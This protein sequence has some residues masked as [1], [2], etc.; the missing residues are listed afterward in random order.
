MPE[1]TALAAAARTLEVRCR[2]A[3][4]GDYVTL[5]HDIRTEGAQPGQ[6]AEVSQ[7]SEV[8]YTVVGHQSDGDYRNIGTFS[9]PQAALTAALLFVREP[10]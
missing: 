5:G 10:G 6:A 4:T 7:L 8:E 9:T 1:E 2:I 3:R